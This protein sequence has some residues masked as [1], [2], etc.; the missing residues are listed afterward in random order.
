M[1]G[2]F[3]QQDASTPNLE[4][5]LQ[6]GIQSARQ[7]NVENARVIFQQVL[8]ADKN[9]ERAWL[10]MASVA[11]TSA[12]R[13]RY[14][15]TVLTI[16]PDNHTAQRELK[17]VESRRQ[18]NNSRVLVYGSI[19]LAVSLILIAVAVIALVVL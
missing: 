2:D 14:L 1:L 7:G 13:Q 6:I 4:Q 15:R 3:D 10:W 8:D 9:N 18:S 5:L 12:D 11:E 17:K 19:A 16:N